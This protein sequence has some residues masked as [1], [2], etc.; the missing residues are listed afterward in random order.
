[1]GQFGFNNEHGHSFC[2]DGAFQRA[3]APASTLLRSSEEQRLDGWD[4]RLVYAQKISVT[5]LPTSL[6]MSYRITG[7][8]RV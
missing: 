3:P 4:W 5:P 1:M 2:S 6:Q 7:L 8:H